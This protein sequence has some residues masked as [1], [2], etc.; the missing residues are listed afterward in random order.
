LLIRIPEIITDVATDVV[1]DVATGVYIRPKSSS[2]IEL[3]LAIILSLYAALDLIWEALTILLKK[4]TALHTKY[5]VSLN[6]S[7]KS[8][9]DYRINFLTKKV[10]DIRLRIYVCPL[11]DSM[12]LSLLR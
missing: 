3:V 1:M 6:K 7:C 4:V 10:S 9:L 8:P 12:R 2:I 11:I 5:V